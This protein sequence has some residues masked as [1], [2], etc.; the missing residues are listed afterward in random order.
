MPPGTPV[1]AVID[2]ATAV[3]DLSSLAVA[4][5]RI[6]TVQDTVLFGELFHVVLDFPEVLEQG[7]DIPLAAGGDWLAAEE[8][9]DP[10]FWARLLGGGPPADPD[11]GDLP[12]LK[13]GTRLVTSFRVYRTNPFLVQTTD[14][15]SPV[16]HV[17]GR[18]AG[19]DETAPI[20]I[21]RPDRWSPWALLGLVAFLVLVLLVARFLWGRR[22]G[23]GEWV[24]REIPAPAWLSA[25]IEMRDLLAQGFLNRGESRPFLDGLAGISRR[26]VTGRYRIAA[27]EMTGREI[28]GACGD[29]GYQSS[30]PGVLARLIDTVDHHRY[31][32]QAAPPGWCRD[33]AVLFF[34]EIGKIRVLPRYTEV[35]A[36]LVRDGEIA[37]KE[38]GRELSAVSGRDTGP[39]SVADGGRP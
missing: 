8:A 12:D 35:P 11:V 38:L 26:F 3:L 21:P 10:G 30:H 9:R 27:R 1:T 22:R 4:P 16:I 28:M 7:P 39:A 17:R 33:Q 32:P 15:Q 14:F 19:T 18:V 29:L 23:H 13:E 25:A 34:A 5:A 2:T 20:R 24:D 6:H 36:G 37:W 31:N